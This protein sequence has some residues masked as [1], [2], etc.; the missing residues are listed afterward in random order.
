MTGVGRGDGG[1]EQRR[2]G[3]A[4]TF[5]SCLCVRV[6]PTPSRHAHT[7]SSCLHIRV[8]PILS[9][10]TFFFLSNPLTLAL[11]IS[12]MLYS[13]FAAFTLHLSPSPGSA[14]EHSSLHFHFCPLPP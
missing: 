1:S 3:Y 14:V 7:F 13:L 6:M 2:D 10:L 9:R 8:M 11:C 12:S 5:S 4:H